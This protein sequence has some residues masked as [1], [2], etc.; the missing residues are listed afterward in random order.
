MLSGMKATLLRIPGSH[1]S[2]AAELMLERKGIEVRR[3]D[4]VAAMHKPIVRAAGFPASTVPAVFLDGQ[5]LQ[6]TARI[7]RALDVLVPEPPLYPRDPEQ[8]AAVEQAE[9]WGDIV[10]QPAVRRTVWS[11]LSRD[12]STLGTFLVDA[13]LGIPTDLAVRTAAPVVWLA[14]HFNRASDAALR[15]DLAAL[16]GRLDHVDGLIADGVIGGAEP[17]VADYQIATSIRLLMTLDDMRPEIEGRPVGKL[18]LDVV[19]EFPGRIPAVFDHS[20]RNGP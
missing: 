3:V 13:K 11:A 12:R 14:S 4:L 9:R 19:P 8:R 15:R 16:P 10:L 6:G 2:F 7:A 5:R 20:V 17:N 1:P 18:A